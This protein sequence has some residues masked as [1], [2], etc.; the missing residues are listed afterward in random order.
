MKKEYSAQI[1]MKMDQI[2]LRVK[3]LS[4][5]AKINIS[6]FAELG[7]S[8]DTINDVINKD[9]SVDTLL[10]LEILFDQSIISI[11]N[12]H[13]AP[14]DNRSSTNIVSF[15]ETFKGKLKRT[16]TEETLSNFIKIL[17]ERQPGY[18][19]RGSDQYVSINY[20]IPTESPHYTRSGDNI[21]ICFF[22]FSRKGIKL[23]LNIPNIYLTFSD[24]ICEK[25]GTP[26]TKEIK[27]SLLFQCGKIKNC[28]LK[29]DKS[30]SPGFPFVIFSNNAEFRNQNFELISIFN[31][32]KE[33]HLKS[34]QISK[35]NQ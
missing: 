2:R 18:Y 8:L 31:Q 16:M 14:I 24:E 6:T 25:V 33:I 22:K 21:H 15:T 27:T 9:F 4:E 34:I 17:L 29:G 32:I 30:Q 3:Q 10:K 20:S 23:E 7:I 12:D 1:Q 28:T 11:Q 35:E 26:I 19:Y 5:T 13:K